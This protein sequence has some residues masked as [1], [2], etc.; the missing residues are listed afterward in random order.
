MCLSKPD[1]PKPKPLQEVKTPDSTAMAAK[2][3]QT[4]GGMAGGTL[5]TGPSGISGSMTNTGANTLLGS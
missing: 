4:Q 5:L 1:I 2:R 3:K